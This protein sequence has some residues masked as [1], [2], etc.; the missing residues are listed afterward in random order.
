MRMVFRLLVS[1]VILALPG[2]AYGDVLST[3]EL[4]FTIKNTVQ[5]SVSPEKAYRRMVDRVDRWWDGAHTFGGDAATMRMEDKVG[6][7]FCEGL[8]NGGEVR[9]LEIIHVQPGKMLR[10]SGGLGPLQSVAV[11]GVMTWDF[12]ATDSGTQISLT[13]TVGG[14]TKNGL[15]DLATPVDHVLKGQLIRLQQYLNTGSPSEP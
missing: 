12:V 9:H 7:C 15:T 5:V 2:M 11:V 10:M 1:I 14:Y 13:Y 6:G 4:G 8:P 3:S